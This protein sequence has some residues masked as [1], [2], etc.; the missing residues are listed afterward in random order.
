[1]KIKLKK[2][3]EQRKTKW[4]RKREKSMGIIKRENEIRKRVK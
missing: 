1:M 3:A 2:E 4:S